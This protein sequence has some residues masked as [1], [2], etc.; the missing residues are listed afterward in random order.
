MWIDVTN[1]DR[2]YNKRFLE[3]ESIQYVK[4]RCRGHSETPTID[5]V[6]TF[7][8]ICRKYEEMHPLEIIVVHC[9]HGFNRTGTVFKS[10][11]YLVTK[12]GFQKSWDTQYFSM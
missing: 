5:Q 7:V 8:E 4:L 2:Y 11:I 10:T 6:K 9:T 12:I 3:Q 1:T